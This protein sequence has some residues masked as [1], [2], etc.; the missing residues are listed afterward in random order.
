MCSP[1]IQ[2]GLDRE[3]LAAAV[4]LSEDGMDTVLLS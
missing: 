2:D 3:G 4:E 1:V